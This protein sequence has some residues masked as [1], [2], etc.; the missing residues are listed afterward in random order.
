VN[1]RRALLATV[2]ILAVASSACG[3]SGNQNATPPSTAAA[4]TTVVDHSADS[5]A[6]L[7]S[8]ALATARQRKWVHTVTRDV[9]GDGVFVATQDAGPDSGRQH[10]ELGDAVEQVLRVSGKTYIKGNTAA[11]Q[12]LP[13]FPKGTPAKLAGKWFLVPRTDPNYADVASGIALGDALDELGL[14]T[15]WKKGATSVRNGQKVVALSATT[16][17]ERDTLYVSALG[18]V[19]PVAMTA[20]AMGTTF[21]TRFSNWGDAVALSAPPVSPAPTN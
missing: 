5:A 16:K 10:V 13:G 17:N 9:S 6:Q 14:K 12:I 2:S 7:Y 4:P 11:I 18:A 3:S 21:E 19:L 8:Q 1:T 15:T 20:T